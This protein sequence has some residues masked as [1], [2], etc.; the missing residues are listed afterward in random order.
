MKKEKSRKTKSGSYNAATKQIHH[1]FGQN[2]KMI[3][4]F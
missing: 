1:V 2:A 3:A 4:T